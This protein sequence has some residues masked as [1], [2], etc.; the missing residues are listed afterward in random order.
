MILGRSVI[1]WLVLIFVGICIFILAKWLIPLVFGL[2]GFAI[3]DQ[4]S[5]ILA[6]LIALGCC[7]GG[8]T[9]RSGGVVT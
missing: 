4:I 7:W 6:L 5:T 3:P 2:I 8:Y 1:H 9:Y